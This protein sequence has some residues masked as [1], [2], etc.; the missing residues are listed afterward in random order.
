[1]AIIEAASFSRYRPRIV[2]AEATGNMT[3][4]N[5]SHGSGRSP[6]GPGHRERTISNLYKKK[7]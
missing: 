4:F 5:S 7:G 1:L 3:A 6:D 2:L